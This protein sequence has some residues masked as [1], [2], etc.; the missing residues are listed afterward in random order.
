MKTEIHQLIDW[1]SEIGAAFGQLRGFMTQIQKV[2][3]RAFLLEPTKLNRVVG[4]IHERLRDHSAY[5]LQD[6]YEVSL[7]NQHVEQT[8]KLEDVLALDNT[9]KHRI[10]RLLVA[11]AVTTADGGDSLSMRFK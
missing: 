1:H 10:Q 7:S 2:Y 5:S 4:V 3:D 8:A 11:C 9:R 6:S